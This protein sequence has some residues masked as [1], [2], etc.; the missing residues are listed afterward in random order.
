MRFPQNPF[1]YIL[2]DDGEKTKHP[3]KKFF[4]YGNK[5][6]RFIYSPN[7]STKK[8][9]GLCSQDALSCGSIY[10]MT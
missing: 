3:Q 6:Y 9:P 10:L 2:G 4:A 5:Y 7:D 1:I 8:H